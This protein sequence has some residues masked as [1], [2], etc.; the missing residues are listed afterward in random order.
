[1]VGVPL[2]GAGEFQ[3]PHV[4]YA[5]TPLHDSLIMQEPEVAKWK[6]VYLAYDVVAP[7]TNDEDTSIFNPLV[8]RPPLDQL[9]LP[10]HVDPR[11]LARLAQDRGMP[12]FARIWSKLP[13]AHAARTG[14][15]TNLVFEVL[16]WGWMCVH[17][18]VCNRLRAN[19]QQVVHWAFVDGQF[20]DDDCFFEQIDEHDCSNDHISDWPELSRRFGLRD[21]GGSNNLQ[22]TLSFTPSKWCP[23]RTLALRLGVE[24]V[25]ALPSDCEIVYPQRSVMTLSRNTCLELNGYVRTAWTVL[26][27]R[28]G[29]RRRCPHRSHWQSMLRLSKNT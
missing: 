19:P 3:L 12:K 7:T 29:H 17:L 22:L 23:E 9:Y 14:D 15:P 4:V 1:M 13:Y 2:V 10:F 6:K 5:P 21:V 18:G 24:H 20:E 28:L 16:Q 26:D 25:N 11:H 27:L 8:E